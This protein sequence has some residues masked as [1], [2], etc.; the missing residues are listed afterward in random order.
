MFQRVGSIRLSLQAAVHTVLVCMV[1]RSW[2]AAGEAGSSSFLWT[3]AQLSLLIA[4]RR[5]P[6][7]TG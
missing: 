3:A 1:S 7:L 5:R 6:H 2:M 4:R